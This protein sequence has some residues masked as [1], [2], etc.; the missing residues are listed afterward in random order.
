MEMVGSEKERGGRATES[1]YGRWRHGHTVVSVIITLLV[2]LCYTLFV[3]HYDNTAPSTLEMLGMLFAVSF[4]GVPHGATDH[5][6]ASDIFKGAFPR[7]WLLVFVV[8]Y[9]ALMGIVVLAW[10][11]FPSASLA[12]FLFMTIVHWGL[13]DVEDDLVPS[14]L[15]YSAVCLSLK[16]RAKKRPSSKRTRGARPPDPGARRYSD[17]PAVRRL[18]AASRRH[19]HVAHRARQRHRVD[20]LLRRRRR[21]RRRRPR[22]D[23]GELRTIETAR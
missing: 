18:P 2:T 1:W 13:G 12:A 14:H 4:F 16:F 3:Q 10:N 20:R 21:F 23:A 8:L 9:L 15:R 11:L 22:R 6:V 17:R 19:L 5:L 7:T